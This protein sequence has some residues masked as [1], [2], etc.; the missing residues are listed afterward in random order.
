M[1]ERMRWIVAAVA[2]LVVMGALVVLFRAPASGV[3]RTTGIEPSTAVEI[4][5]PGPADELLRQQAEL[6][7][8]RPLF[9]PTP[10]NAALREPRREPSRTF[11]EGEARSLNISEPELHPERDLPPIATLGGVPTANARPADGLGAETDLAGVV[12]IGRRPVA[13]NPL[14]ERGGVVEVVAARDGARLFAEILPVA[15]RPATTS[16][17]GALEFLA[18]VD[19]AG[20]SSELVLTE[21]SRVE[22]V[23]A[24]FRRYLT[25]TYHI[26]ARLPPGYYRITVAP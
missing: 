2:S 14:R 19:A 9:L 11:L 17:W 22:E 16:P 25:G 18:N 6:R 15:A 5:Q 12:G 24:H 13:V 26:G 4:A 1:P 3:A 7:D 21:G 8:L 10:R 20:L 23:D